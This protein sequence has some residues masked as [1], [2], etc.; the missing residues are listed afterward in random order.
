[1]FNE[2]QDY[3]PARSTKNIRNK[4]GQAES[5]ALEELL[6]PVFLRCNITDKTLP[7]ECFSGYPAGCL[8]AC[9]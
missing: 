5:G 8:V 9:I 2:V 4:R 7:V 1:M 6:N 3:V